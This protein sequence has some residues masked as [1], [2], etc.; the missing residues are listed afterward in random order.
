MYP[1]REVDTLLEPLEGERVLRRAELMIRVLDRE[2]ISALA[3]QL[4]RQMGFDL[5]VAE[6][7]FYDTPR[8]ETLSGTCEDRARSG[9]GTRRGSLSDVVACFRVAAG[10]RIAPRSVAA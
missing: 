10:N 8:E 1:H 5:S 3:A 4:E 7:A 9:G 2:L 6:R